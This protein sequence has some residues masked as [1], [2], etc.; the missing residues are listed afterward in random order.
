MVT[1]GSASH[2]ASIVAQCEVLLVCHQSILLNTNSVCIHYN[3]QVL[4]SKVTALPI[5]PP[6][7]LI[8]G[9][10]LHYLCLKRA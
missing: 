1:A 7:A 8:P 9:V 10:V 5:M 3:P 6:L 2:A 4:S